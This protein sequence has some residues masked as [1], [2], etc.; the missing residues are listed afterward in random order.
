MKTLIVYASKYGTTTDCATYLKDKLA[1][2]VTLIDINGQT[3]PPNLKDFD[4]I[5]IG[6]S[7]Y[8]GTLSKKLK[9]F[10]QTNLDTLLQKKIGLFLCC[11]L[12]EEVED[13]F[14]KNFPTTLL[15]HGS[16]RSHFGSEARLE[17]MKFLDKTVLK[18]VTKGDFTTFNISYEKIENFAQA[19]S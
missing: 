15:E 5:V 18:A 4:T 12:G 9:T 14:E 16:V 19:L 13:F 3:Q 2:E 10:C 17:K 7:I 8:A 1:G 6:G 11:G